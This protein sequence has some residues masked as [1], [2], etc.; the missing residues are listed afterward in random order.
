MMAAG[1]KIAFLTTVFGSITFILP[2]IGI[3]V[4]RV[5]QKA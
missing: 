4:L 2:R 5:L 3:I 1:L